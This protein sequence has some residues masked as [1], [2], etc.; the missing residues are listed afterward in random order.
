MHSQ[1]EN[2]SL[3]LAWTRECMNLY[4]FG[5]ECEFEN[6]HGRLEYI[7]IPKYRNHQF[8]SRVWYCGSKHTYS[9]LS[10]DQAKRM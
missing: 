8:E 9:K 4:T 7:S 5:R 6:D 1:T 10:T 2:D 3:P